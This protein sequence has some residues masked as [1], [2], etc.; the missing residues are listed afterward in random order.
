LKRSASSSASPPEARRLFIDRCAW[1][2]ALGRALS[3]A[4]IAF[5]AHHAHFRDDTPD[6]EWLTA[7]TQHRWL[8][9]TRDKRIRYKPNELAAMRAARLHVFVFTQG[10]LSAGETGEILVRCH[11]ARQARAAE[12][13]PPAFFSLTRG[14]DVKPMKLGA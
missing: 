3:D 2:A 10:G 12:T 1:S 6:A 11:A 5:E 7:A 9:V 8:I 4:G 13:T 14:G